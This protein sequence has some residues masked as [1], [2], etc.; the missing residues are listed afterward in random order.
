MLPLETHVE[1]TVQVDKLI[2][3]NLTG[4]WYESFMRRNQKRNSYQQEVL[5]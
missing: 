1:S 3:Q 4:C 2:I 5:G